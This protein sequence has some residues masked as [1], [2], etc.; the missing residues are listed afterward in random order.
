MMEDE[1]TTGTNQSEGPNSPDGTDEQK[2]S[3]N[4]VVE[5]SRDKYEAYINLIPLKDSPAIS[6][7]EIN[8]ALQEKNIKFGIDS[9][10][11]NSLVN[12][13]RFNEKILIALGTKP[14]DGKDGFIDY[15]I[16]T[17]K[18]QKIKKGEK[19]GEITEPEAGTEGITVHEEKIPTNEGKK[20][21][22][23]QL[24]NA[25]FS[26]END[27]LII[28]IENG[29]V[30]VDRASIEVMPFFEL[31][32]LPSKLEA[33]VNVIE[34]LEAGD[35]NADDLKSFLQDNKIVYGIKEDAIQN[36]FREEKYIERILIAKG[37][38][39]DHGQDGE[40]KYYFETKIKPKEDEHGNL[41]FKELTLIQ[42][43]E[44]DQKIA[45]AIPPVKGNE[46]CDIFGENIPPKDVIAAALPPGKN[47]YADPNNPNIL[48]AAIDGNVKLRGKNIDVNPVFLVKENVDFETGNIDF[49]GSVFIKGDVKSGFSVK[50]KHDI[51]INGIVEDAILEA[52]GEIL[53]KGGF[54]GKGEG[55]ITAQGKVIAQFCDNQQ[56]FCEGDI[57]IHDYVMHSHIETKGNLTVTS[58]TGLIVGGE[59]YALKGIVAKITG[60]DNYT[61]TAIF[62]GVDKE[63]M[64][65]IKELRELLLKNSE[66]KN[67]INKAFSAL[68]EL[69][70]KMK[71]LP[72]EKEMLFEKVVQTR[73]KIE[74]EE[75]LLIE[76][77]EELEA[78]LG[79]Y[80]N[81]MLKVLDT[82]YPGTVVTIY[83]RHTEV[84]E[85]LKY[86][87][88]KYTD[89]KPIAV[90]L[91]ELKATA[92]TPEVKQE[93]PETKELPEDKEESGKD[94]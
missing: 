88:Y 80:K 16:D 44:K 51:Q 77:I 25:D 73:V 60:N 81:S 71:T 82:V 66:N 14:E 42:N 37:D 46:G 35:F 41:D 11:I 19:I 18:P 56:I 4:L 54:V 49:L 31:E 43:V 76:E 55:K 57:E 33:Y 84:N 53:L 68:S 85:P 29:Y 87:F 5:V 13:P 58:Q 45:E 8:N 72:K 64:E 74:E 52:G 63:T 78:K 2:E 22:L 17:G 62:I 91:D 3:V 1:I 32:I 27:N 67:E 86:V 30:T 21:Q 40:I 15:S 48:L 36:I 26:P 93:A 38:E 24:K 23:P 69:K 70:Y 65:R 20:L 90:D 12:E 47:V 9:E 61:Q 28:A 79:E 94:K 89:D 50:A 83:N 10:Q 34:P 7:D 6:A 59:I 92:P 75:R 39:V